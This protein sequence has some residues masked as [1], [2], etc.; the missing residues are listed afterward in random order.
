MTPEEKK[1]FTQISHDIEDIKREVVGSERLDYTDG[2]G[3]RLRR[4]E[5][6]IRSLKDSNRKMRTLL[7][8]IAYG[9]GIGGLIFGFI[10]IKELVGFI[11]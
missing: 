1:E 5:E 10:T 9:I 8:G 11:K 7:I 4:V 3:F 2:M 6:D